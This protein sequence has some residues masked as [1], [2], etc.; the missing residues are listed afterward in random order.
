ML[1]VPLNNGVIAECLHYLENSK[2][3]STSSTTPSMANNNNVTSNLSVGDVLLM[4]PESCQSVTNFQFPEVPK[5]VIDNIIVNCIL[6]Y[7]L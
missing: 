1:K 2:K 4:L 3:N 7:L 5:D 6:L